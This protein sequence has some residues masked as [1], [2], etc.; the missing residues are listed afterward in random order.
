MDDNEHSTDI[1]ST[2]DHSG[3]EDQ[4]EDDPA[5]ETVTD[6]EAVTMN[7]SDDS[8]DVTP[9][10]GI[11]PRPDRAPQPTEDSNQSPETVQRQ[12]DQ[13]PQSIPSQ[14][15]NTAAGE[16]TVGDVT[17]FDGEEL[18][19]DIQPGWAA[20]WWDLA[21]GTF[22]VMTM[23]GVIIAPYWYYKA[24]KK[25]KNTHYIITSDRLILQKGGLTS[26]SSEEYQ[27]QNLDTIST[28]Q[29]FFEGMVNK[30]TVK[31]TLREQYRDDKEINLGGIREYND[32]K[33]TIR[34]EQYN[35]MN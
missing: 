16:Q 9:S 21:I 12:P 8:L 23:I 34:R 6:A 32:V 11:E 35:E 5:A 33:T 1:E 4:T 15:V 30:G 10:E 18:H 19:H 29:G 26:T 28:S 3:G 24:Y 20:Y 14:P 27:F 7:E 31:L 22:M 25:K 2:L 13:S 17:I